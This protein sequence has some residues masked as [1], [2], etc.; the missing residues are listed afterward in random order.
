MPSKEDRISCSTT[1]VTIKHSACGVL[2]LISARTANVFR[3]KFLHNAAHFICRDAC[4]T[5]FICISNAGSRSTRVHYCTSQWL[6]SSTACLGCVRAILIS[7]CIFTDQLEESCLTSC[8]SWFQHLFL[9]SQRWGLNCSLSQSL[10]GIGKI[11]T[12][13][14]TAGA[15]SVFRLKFLHN[16]AHFICRDTCWTAFICISNAGSRSTRAHYCT[17]QWLASSTACLGCVRAILIS[18]CIFTD[19]LEESC[20]TSCCSWFQHLFLSSQRCGLNCSL[21]QSL[22]GIGKIGTPGR[23]AGA[24]SVFRLKFLHNA[25]HFICRDTCWTA[26]ICIS[27]AGSRSTRAHYCT[28]Q[29]LASSTAC[30]GCVRAILISTC[31]FTDQLEESCLTSCWICKYSGSES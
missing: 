2:Q 29:W 16:A 30:L 21:S 25:A 11:G 10:T 8:C 3:L 28:S 23:T 1:G 18:T 14:R 9:S 26:F 31:I 27:N 24:A 6:A 20:L 7:T 4:W 17:S 15:A 12:P 13:G 22:T 5:A 19:Q